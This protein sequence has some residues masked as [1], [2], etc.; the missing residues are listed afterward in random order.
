MNKRDGSLLIYPDVRDD[1]E[2]TNPI[3]FTNLSSRKYAAIKMLQ[4]DAIPKWPTL[5]PL[6]RPAHHTFSFRK[7]E[8]RND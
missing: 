5:V 6:H 1:T 2:A 7:E 8:L 4:T 3:I